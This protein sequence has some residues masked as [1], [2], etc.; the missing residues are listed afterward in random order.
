MTQEGI[1][2]EY[3]IVFLSGLFALFKNNVNIV[4]LLKYFRPKQPGPFK[5][6][7]EKWVHH[8]GDP[9]RI[10]LYFVS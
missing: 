7:R 10:L 8:V 1:F 9:L 2:F 5:G 6:L 4:I 3:I